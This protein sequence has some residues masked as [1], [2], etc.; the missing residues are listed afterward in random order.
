MVCQSLVIYCFEIFLRLFFFFF[1]SSRRR[2]TRYWR[3][4]SSDVCSSD[5]VGRT[6]RAARLARDLYHRAIAVMRV[7]SSLGGFVSLDEEESF[8][9]E[10][11]PLELYKLSLAPPPRELQ[12]AVAL[13]RKSVV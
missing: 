4:W 12:G 8:A 6:V 10:Y 5:L 13:D 9:I 1:F 11:W 7:A 2:H 3:D